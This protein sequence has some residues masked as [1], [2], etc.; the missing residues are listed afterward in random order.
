MT[1]T[2][3]KEICEAVKSIDELDKLGEL[4]SIIEEK[5]DNFSTD[6]DD[7]ELSDDDDSDDSEDV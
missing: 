7:D 2:R 1:L 6:D 5:I 3:F 4:M